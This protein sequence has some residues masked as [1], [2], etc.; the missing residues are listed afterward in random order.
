MTSFLA[1]LRLCLIRQ[2]VDLINLFFGPI[3]FFYVD[4][5]LAI[6]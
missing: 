1:A 6:E 2:A 3:K 4:I 5:R